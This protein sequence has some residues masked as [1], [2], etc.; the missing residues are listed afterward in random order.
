MRLSQ[1]KNK[2]STPCRRWR[3]CAFENRARSDGLRLLRWQRLKDP[4]LQ[5][6]EAQMRT[7]HNQE[8]QQPLTW[9]AALKFFLVDGA[10]FAYDDFNVK[11]QHPELTDELYGQCVQ[12]RLSRGVRTAASWFDCLPRRPPE[13]V[14]NCEAFSAQPLPDSE[15]WT[16]EETRELWRLCERLDLRWPVIHDRFSGSR[17]VEEL[18][19]RYF[20]VAKRFVLAN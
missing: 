8:L 2:R 5:Q 10:P 16:P 15:N 6:L 18:K 20:Q 17:S 9:N 13:R 19:E 7:L 11:I 4:Q 1:K 3:L 14:K 12:V